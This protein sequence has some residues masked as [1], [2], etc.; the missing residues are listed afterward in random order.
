MICHH[1]RYAII[2]FLCLS[3]DFSSAA[4]R[5]YT[6][7]FSPSTLTSQQHS[8]CKHRICSHGADKPVSQTPQ[9][10]AHNDLK[11]TADNKSYGFWRQ[12]VAVPKI[13]TQTA[14]TSTAFFANRTASALTHGSTLPQHLLGATATAGR[15]LYASIP[16]RETLILAALVSSLAPLFILNATQE[17]HHWFQPEPTYPNPFLQNRTQGLALAAHPHDR[18]PSY[19]LNLSAQHVHTPIMALSAIMNDVEFQKILFNHVVAERRNPT[20]FTTHAYFRRADTHL[21][22]KKKSQALT[23]PLRR[24]LKDYPLWT[25][26][27]CS[28]FISPS[29][30]EGGAKAYYPDC[31][32]IDGISEIWEHDPGTHAVHNTFLYLFK[33]LHGAVRTTELVANSVFPFPSGNDITRYRNPAYSS[34]D[35]YTRLITAFSGTFLN[36]QTGARVMLSLPQTDQVPLEMALVGWMLNNQTL[37]TLYIEQVLDI[38]HKRCTATTAM[39]QFHTLLQEILSAHGANLH[40]PIF[41]D[42]DVSRTWEVGGAVM[43]YLTCRVPDSLPQ[44]IIVR[45][46]SC[47]EYIR[48]ITMPQNT[49]LE[50]SPYPNGKLKNYR[51]MTNGG[52]KSPRRRTVTP[53]IPVTQPPR[54]PTPTRS[55]L[56]TP[57]DRLSKSQSLTGPANT[58]TRALTLSSSPSSSFSPAAPLALINMQTALGNRTVYGTNITL[59]ERLLSCRQTRESSYIHDALWRSSNDT[60]PI[61]GQCPMGYYL[62]QNQTWANNTYF[63]G[64]NQSAMGWN[65]L[66]GSIQTDHPWNGPF[67]RESSVVFNQ[68]MRGIFSGLAPAVQFSVIDQFLN[69]STAKTQTWPIDIARIIGDACETSASE[70]PLTSASSWDYIT[71]RNEDRTYFTLPCEGA[72]SIYLIGGWTCEANPN[73]PISLEEYRCNSHVENYNISEGFKAGCV[74]PG[75]IVL[76]LTPVTLIPNRTSYTCFGSGTFVSYTNTPVKRIALPDGENM[77]QVMRNLTFIN[78]VFSQKIMSELLGYP[79]VSQKD[80]TDFYDILKEQSLSDNAT[81][82]Y[83]SAR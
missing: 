77:T 28:F 83:G 72:S 57:T 70:Y 2:I 78:P 32:N 71:R 42:A 50:L 15:S 66:P 56:K 1:I 68:N 80:K 44:N 4:T 76:K 46:D 45:H 24:M 82:C 38:R 6:E 27:V 79:D 48:G 69:T 17:Y 63:F 35:A 22:H 31:H 19:V 16:P 55:R 65:I 18:Q 12:L 3:T 58:P 14:R 47:F 59:Y 13:V 36:S 20:K 67:V 74:K 75:K 62:F 73:C 41:C 49:H 11:E 25:D 30:A 5:H 54:I 51:L 8:P 43:R 53:P 33:D 29:W 34:P 39:N 81:S 10:S 61:Y 21:M 64:Y 26:I 40:Q 52:F 60:H 9:L 7:S 23:R 37:Q